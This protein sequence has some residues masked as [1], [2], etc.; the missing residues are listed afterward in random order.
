MYAPSF[1]LYLCCSACIIMCIIILGAGG[2]SS[3]QTV[4]LPRSA[5]LPRAC[6][7]FALTRSRRSE[8]DDDGSNSFFLSCI[9]AYA[10]LEGLIPSPIRQQL[11]T[12][13]CKLHSFD[14]HSHDLGFL[15]TMSHPRSTLQSIDSTRLSCECRAR[16]FYRIFPPLVSRDREQ[17]LRCCK[18]QLGFPAL[19]LS[20]G[21][22][23]LC[24]PQWNNDAGL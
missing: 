19:P 12:A 16:I 14:T 24:A 7:T 6:H 18:H 10:D 11:A 2:S 3:S 5:I 20:K 22:S 23:T 15:Q 8:V 21:Y 17:F 9:G 4:S 13:I 1:A